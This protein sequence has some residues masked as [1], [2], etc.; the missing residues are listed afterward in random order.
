MIA[1]KFYSSVRRKKGSNPLKIFFAADAHIRAD[2]DGNP[3]ATGAIGGT[4]YFYTAGQKMQN[5]VDDVNKSYPDLVYFGGD[6]IEEWEN[7]GS[8]DL[9]MQKWNQINSG[10]RKELTVGN[11]DLAWS[12]S[13]A[14]TD[15]ATKYG[16]GS[17]PIV[18]GSKYNQSFVLTNGKNTL[19]IIAVDTNI[20]ENG[21]HQVVTAQ[22]LKQPIRD[23][24]ESEL[25]NSPEKNIVIFSHA[26]MEDDLYHFNETDAQAFK[27]MVDRVIS[28]RPE[29]KI[30]N[31]YGH[32]HQPDI[33][34]DDRLGSSVKSYSIPA[35]VEN[36]VGNYVE[37]LFSEQDGLSL[38][39]HNLVY[40]YS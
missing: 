9:F 35:V 19:R 25:L 31:I 24:L 33:V 5:F 26:G 1:N 16:Y 17:R 3:N 36:E 4:R 2:V 11:H 7:V 38:I 18:A 29:L 22:T 40:P 34:S 15:M 6:M 37:I 21:N 12:P 23:W 8:A 13:L 32:R 27:T 28:Q 30:Y 39:K 10:I 20:D 14:N